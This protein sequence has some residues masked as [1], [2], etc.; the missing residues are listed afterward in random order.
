MNLGTR[1]EFKIWDEIIAN[2]QNVEL[3]HSPEEGCGDTTENL[4]TTWQ[5]LPSR[6]SHLEEVKETLKNVDL[7]NLPCN[8]GMSNLL[9]I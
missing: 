3:L 6:N 1:N 7:E 4:G 2:S 5:L 9:I 8:K